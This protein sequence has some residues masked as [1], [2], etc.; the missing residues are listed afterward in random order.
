MQTKE[1]SLKQ[2]V[3]AVLPGL[4]LLPYQAHLMESLASVGSISELKSRMAIKSNRKGYLQRMKKKY[5]KNGEG[6]SQ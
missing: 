1:I 6:A 5:L 2:F 4:E 3:R